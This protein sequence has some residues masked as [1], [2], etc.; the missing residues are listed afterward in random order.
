M[1][2]VAVPVS[3]GQAD[4]GGGTAEHP[5]PQIG[6]EPGRAG[7]H[8]RGGREDGAAGPL[9]GSSRRAVSASSP[10]VPRTRPARR[11]RAAGS[12]W[13]VT[14][15]TIVASHSAP[16]GAISP[17]N[18]ASAS[19]APGIPRS[20][21]QIHMQHDLRRASQARSGRQFDADQQPARLLQGIVLALPP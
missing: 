21:S 5:G 17:G 1:E 2:S 20:R 11:S 6:G 13:P 10:P 19:A 9:G 3:S 4:R 8:V 12:T 18:V 7:Q 14:T 15:G 16:G